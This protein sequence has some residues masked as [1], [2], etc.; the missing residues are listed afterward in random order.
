MKIRNW[1]FIPILLIGI[2]LVPS[3]S[4]GNTIT[5]VDS[6]GSV[7]W[8]S[9]LTIGEDGNPI[10][11]Y[12]DRTTSDWA[13]K[14]VKCGNGSCNSGNSFKTVDSTE[15]AG[16]YSA[17]A[18]GQD[19]LPVISYYARENYDLKVAK[20]ADFACSTATIT[21]V[22]AGGYVGNFTSIAI[23]KDNLPIIS[24]LYFSGNDLR[25]AHCG[26]ASCTSA[27]IITTVESDGSAGWYTSIAIGTDDWPVIAHYAAGSLKV[28]KCGNESCTLNNTLTTVDPGVASWDISITVGAD[29]MPVIS[30]CDNTNGDLKVAKCINKSCSESETEKNIITTVDSEG[31]VGWHT[32]IAI[33]ADGLPIISYW[34][35]SH[36]D[37]KVVKCGNESCSSGNVITTIDS[38]GNVGWYTSIAI[39]N[40]KR[41]VISY[42]DATNKDLKVV[43]CATHSCAPSAN[44][45]A[46]ILLLGD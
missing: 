34:D 27:N 15:D 21:T 45:P 12:Q 41:P 23:G 2:L 9:S 31:R 30:Y 17:I 16:E 43:K 46:T 44:L 14:V 6:D 35:W 11:S 22:D 24:Y 5:T 32:S 39:G 7:G 13:L 3:I 36:G 8:Y 29:D 26:N 20:C 1:K 18:I 42:Y 25:T 19:S 37:L 10:I 4:S 33:G 38:E 28:A 40:D